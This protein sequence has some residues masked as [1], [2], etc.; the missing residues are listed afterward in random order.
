MVDVIAVVFGNV[1]LT[2]DWVSLDFRSSLDIVGSSTRH[3][4]SNALTCFA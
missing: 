1:Y 4:T 3:N 2:L